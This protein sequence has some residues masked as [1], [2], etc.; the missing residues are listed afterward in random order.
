MKAEEF[1]NI[2]VKDQYGELVTI[3]EIHGNI[4]VENGTYNY[5]HTANIFYKGKSVYNWL[6]EENK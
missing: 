6:N 4:A 5:Y 1:R 2:T 3:L